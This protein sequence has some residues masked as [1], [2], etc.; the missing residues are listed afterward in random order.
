MLLLLFQ[1]L[2]ETALD[3]FFFPQ[4]LFDLCNEKETA[5]ARK[6]TV[7]GSYSQVCAPSQLS[8]STPAQH[9]QCFVPAERERQEN[10]P[11][12]S[13]FG[14]LKEEN[15]GPKQ[16]FQLYQLVWTGLAAS[17]RKGGVPTHRARKHSPGKHPEGLLGKKITRTDTQCRD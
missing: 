11:S 4:L 8:S 15:A 6:S 14:H 7:G 2:L 1:H 17:M 16:K 10:P 13:C 5:S 9:H 12:L 3:E